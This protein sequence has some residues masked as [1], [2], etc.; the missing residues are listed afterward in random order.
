MGR[1][2]K[3]TEFMGES[4]FAFSFTYDDRRRID[5]GAHIHELAMIIFTSRIDF[6]IGR[7]PY[8]ADFT[9]ISS[10]ASNTP[11][12]SESHRRIRRRTGMAV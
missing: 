6:Q 10:P 7:S 9:E 4:D 3:R 2:R 1:V 5:L 8:L 11:S 12:P